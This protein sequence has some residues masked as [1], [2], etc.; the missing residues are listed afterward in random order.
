M[1]WILEKLARVILHP[2]E[3]I[4]YSHARLYRPWLLAIVFF[5]HI[6]TAGFV[7]LETYIFT[8]LDEQTAQ[9]I[10]ATN[11]FIFL[12]VFIGQVLSNRI[13]SATMGYSSVLSNQLDFLQNVND[14]MNTLME[15]D[16][17][18]HPVPSKLDVEAADIGNVSGTTASR[19]GYEQPKIVTES[20]RRV[21]EE[22][23]ENAVSE[24]GMIRRDLASQL[25]TLVLLMYWVSSPAK[26]VAQEVLK[27]LGVSHEI[28][29]FQAYD[30]LPYQVEKLERECINAV[31]MYSR[32]P[33]SRLSKLAYLELVEIGKRLT[34]AVA[35]K[36]GAMCVPAPP[37]MAVVNKIALYTYYILL[38][39]TV[40]PQTV[41]WTVLWY[42]FVQD[43]L[44]VAII[45]DDWLASP[46][47]FVPEDEKRWQPHQR[48]D[49]WLACIL[50]NITAFESPGTVNTDTN[51]VFYSAQN[52][53]RDARQRMLDMNKG[54]SFSDLQQFNEKSK[55]LEREVVDPGNSVMY[56]ESSNPRRG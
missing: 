26:N 19:F 51:K 22:K 38:P 40:I 7:A 41:W 28:A 4:F 18:E 35:S 47:Q 33:K 36:I 24:L 31:M 54:M 6:F 15:C 52:Y 3:T 50:R 13:S 17:E 56:N 32:S 10:A 30:Q 14:L 37:V 25:R 55:Q 8:L 39:I 48:Y 11:L 12:G 20:M 53:V 21:A 34:A 44:F 29:K 45:V 2:V 49:V 23:A 9:T 1:V 43:V 46:I 27:R 5:Y 16:T 42:P